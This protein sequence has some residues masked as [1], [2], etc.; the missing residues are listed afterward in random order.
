[1]NGLVSEW[2]GRRM[3]GERQACVS[4]AQGHGVTKR[5][6]QVWMSSLTFEPAP[7][8]PIDRAPLGAQSVQWAAAR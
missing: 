3:G 7:S 4:P 1:M 5:Q 2:V 8:S 6:S